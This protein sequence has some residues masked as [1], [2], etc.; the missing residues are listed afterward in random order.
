VGTSTMNT[1]IIKKEL[2]YRT[3]RSGGKGGQNVN[4][5]ETKVEIIFNPLAS[6]AFTEDEKAR[7]LQRL[8]P[9]LTKEGCLQLTAQEERSQLANKEI[10]EKK[11]FQVLHHALK[12]EKV[13]KPSH[14]PKG[15]LIAR[16]KDKVANG[17]K[18]ATRKK[19]SFSKEDTDLFI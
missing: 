13:R 8:A 15:V 5:V 10:V 12:V 7:L 19:V 1:E 16:R 9:Q 4:K 14:V 17:I 6:E 3:S 18:K 11:L 2:S